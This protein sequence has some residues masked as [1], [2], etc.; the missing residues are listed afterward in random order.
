MPINNNTQIPGSGSGVPEAPIDGKTYGRKDASWAEVITSGYPFTVGAASTGAIYTTIQLGK[1]AMVKLFENLEIK[2]FEIV[3]VQYIT[4]HLKM[5]G[6][7]EIPYEEYVDLLVSA[8][9]KEIS[10]NKLK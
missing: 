10:L 3:D 4:D 9:K 1:C 8:Y 2:G 5:F 6:T 7:I